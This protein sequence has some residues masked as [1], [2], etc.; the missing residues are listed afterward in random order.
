MAGFRF[1][2]G[3]GKVEGLGFR[4]TFF[5]KNLKKIKNNYPVGK[6][7]RQ[8][9]GKTGVREPRRPP[10]YVGVSENWGGGGPYNKDPT[11]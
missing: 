10:N 11:I 4:V 6:S 8:Q 7:S 3:A 1:S 2:F 9:L 5:K